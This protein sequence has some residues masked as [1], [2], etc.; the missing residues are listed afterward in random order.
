MPSL[1]RRSALIGALLAAPALASVP[2]RAETATAVSDPGA[3]LAD[4]ERRHGGRLGVTILDVATGARTGWRQDE[5]FL[6]CST[7]KALLAAHVLRRVDAG[8]ETLDRRIPVGKADLVPWSPVAETFVGTPGMTVAQLCDAAVTMSDNAAA[9]LLHAASGGPAALTAFVRGLGDAVSR[10]DRTEPALNEHDHAGDERDTVAPAS[11]AAT[12]HALLFEEALSRRSR[13]L[14]RGWLVT[15]RT[16]DARLRAGFPATWLVGDKTG[17]N[18]SGTAADVAAVWPN[19][20]PPLV[21]TAY[22]EVRGASADARNAVLAEV[23]RIA[24]T[25]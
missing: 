5:R 12:L 15:N 18:G 9:N 24:A 1:T 4:L 10:F 2:L 19:T 16:G 6:A 20:R 21:V 22:Y 13:D 11:M 7:F 17:T 14:L 25:M 23:G 8:Q 3:R